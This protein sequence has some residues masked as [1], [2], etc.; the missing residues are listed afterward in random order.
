[1]YDFAERDAS[2]RQPKQVHGLPAEH[3]GLHYLQQAAGNAAVARRIH[4]A[5]QRERLGHIR[6]TAPGTR[7]PFR[8]VSASFDGRQFVLT[9]DGRERIRVAAQSGHP[10]TVEASDAAACRGSPEE[11]YMNNSRYVGV[12]DRGSI[13]EG[14]YEFRPDQIV[15]FSALERLRMISGGQFEDVRGGRLHGGD[16]GAGRVALRPVRILPGP[17][18]CGD[19]SRRSGFFLHRLA[20]GAA[21]LG[22][23]GCTA[24]PAYPSRP[25]RVG[26][27]A[28]PGVRAILGTCGASLWRT[29]RP[30]SPSWRRR[31]SRRTVGF[32]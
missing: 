31:W 16:W 7:R 2:S 12:R 32:G 30:T 20:L 24:R 13:P 29:R 26:V 17:P 28:G 9:A 6:E 23:R 19:T 25:A 15:E 3:R 5:V 10:N 4:L 27:V 21:A 14:T 8:T 22:R 18:G 1:M 11:S